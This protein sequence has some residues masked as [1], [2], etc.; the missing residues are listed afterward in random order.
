[1]GPG[2]GGEA[3]GPRG[4]R[5]REGVGGETSEALVSLARLGGVDCLL[6]VPWVVLGAV[7][8]ALAMVGSGTG[9]VCRGLLDVLLLPPV[10]LL[11]LL[12]IAST[13]DVGLP[14]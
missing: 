11:V 1:M 8:G 5:V 10:S 9:L 2:F 12:E 14:C 4:A 3:S 6:L 7:F 13:F